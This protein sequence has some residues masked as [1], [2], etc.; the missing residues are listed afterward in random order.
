MLK[1]ILTKL[2]IQKLIYSYIPLTGLLLQFA[3]GLLLDCCHVI[4]SGAAALFRV[5]LPCC[6]I[7]ISSG[8]RVFLLYSDEKE[9]EVGGEGILIACV[10]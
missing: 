10:L 8:A 4:P 1:K 2:T 7:V 6:P 9:K 3:I 5:V